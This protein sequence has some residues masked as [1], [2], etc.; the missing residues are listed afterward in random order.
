MLRA[1][2]APTHRRPSLGAL[3][4]VMGIGPLATDAYLPGL[5]ALQQSLDTTAATAQLTL[6]ASSSASRSASW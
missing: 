3:V 2:R 5:P 6:T 4:L 1:S